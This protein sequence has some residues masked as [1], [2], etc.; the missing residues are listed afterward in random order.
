VKKILLLGL[1]LISAVNAKEPEVINYVLNTDRATMFDIGMLRTEIAAQRLVD[2]LDKQVKSQSSSSVDYTDSKINI[3]YNIY[4]FATKKYKDNCKKSIDDLKFR[5]SVVNNIASNF[6]HFG[7]M[8]EN[9]PKYFKEK[10]LELSHLTLIFREKTDGRWNEVFS[11]R[12]TLSKH[13]KIQYK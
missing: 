10:V 8:K 3:E 9:R 4:G 13:S 11:C 7:F 2:V 1:L 6:D 5:L 12:T